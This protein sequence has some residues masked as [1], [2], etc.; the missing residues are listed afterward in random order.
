MAVLSEYKVYVC[1]I[2]KQMPLAAE[3][4]SKH[5]QLDTYYMLLIPLTIPVTIVAVRPSLKQQSTF[6]D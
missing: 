4:V 3:T 2:C 6:R 5:I 1:P